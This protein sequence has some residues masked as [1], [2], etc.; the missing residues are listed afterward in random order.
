MTNVRIDPV[1]TE[2]QKIRTVTL[3][4]SAVKAAMAEK[5]SGDPFPK[6]TRVTPATLSLNLS[7]S[8]ANQKNI[9]PLTLAQFLSLKNHQI[10]LKED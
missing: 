9:L 8:F 1:Y 4:S 2:C 3:G 5:I 10:I 7:W 6:A